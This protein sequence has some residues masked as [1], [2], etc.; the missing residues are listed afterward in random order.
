MLNWFPTPYPDELLYSVLARYH[1]RSGNVS[2][3]MTTEELFGKRTVRAVWDLPANLN[4]LQSKTGDYWTAEQLIFNYTMYPYYAAFLLPQQAKQ[5]MQSMM[6]N[7]GST[8]HTRIGVAASNVKLKKN[9]WVCSDCIKEDMAAY[10]ETYW[11]RTHQCPGVFICPKHE[12][13][14]E[15]TVVSAK[16]F[17]QHEYIIATPMV[18]KSKVNLKGFQKEEIQMLKQIAKATDSLLNN[19]N[20]QTTDNTLRGKYLVLLKQMG[21]ASPNGFVKRDKIYPSFKAKFSKHFLELL[22]SNVEFKE[23][24]W[25]T[26]IF[27]KHR[28]SFHPI[29]HLLVMLFLDTDLNHLFDINKYQP[30]G[31]APWL[32]LNVACPNF[33]KPVVTDLTITIDYDTRKPVG[34][35]R[36]DCGF[37]YS[38]RGPDQ[39]REDRIRIGR[40]KEYGHIWRGRLSDL[41]TEGKKLMEIS[42][43]LNSDR[44]TIKKYAAE[45]ELTVPW[46]SPRNEKKHNDVPFEDYE[47]QLTERKNK[48]LELQK[49][50]PEKSKT[51]LR[52]IAPDVYAYLYRN[53]REWLQSFSPVKTKKQTPNRRVNWEK[54]DEEMLKTIMKVVQSWDKNVEKPTRITIT[55]IGIK[56]NKLSLLQKFAD[57]IP[58]TIDYIHKVSEDTLMF[59]R[60]RVEWCVEKLKDEG[61]PIIEWKIY[62]KAGLRPTVSNDVKRLISLRVTEYESAKK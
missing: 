15:E 51:E 32:C 55:S 28:K 56:I 24:D 27:Q 43:E 18:E 52:K 57:K 40:I 10:G 44:A 48:W 3:K 60:R 49:L 61:E 47:K 50:Y 33:R 46:K 20:L 11:H 54:R 41:V 37:V 36:C 42:R 13:L 53:D 35:F 16:A 26:M 30:F 8:I 34:T 25:L 38:R 5:V 7:K 23:A 45:L 31:K 1:V 4:T 62:K 12:V 59:Q 2:P 19:R 58:K 9:Y 29:R 14:L 17:N 22:Q 6:G 39:T 21:Y